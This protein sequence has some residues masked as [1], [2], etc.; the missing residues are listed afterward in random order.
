MIEAAVVLFLY[1]IHGAGG[2]TFGAGVLFARDCIV[3]TKALVVVGIT[4][5]VLLLMVK[6]LSPLIALACLYLQFPIEG[7]RFLHP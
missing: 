6:A 1:L 3:Y 5:P 7:V 2:T 4:F